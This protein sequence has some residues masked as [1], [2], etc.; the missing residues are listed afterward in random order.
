MGY[1]ACDRRQSLQEI[2][3]LG[4]SLAT[5]IVA[6]RSAKVALK[7]SHFLSP[8][9]LAWL[10]RMRQKAEPSR[11][12]ITRQEPRN[13]DS[14]LLLRESSIKNRLVLW[15]KVTA[16]P[17]RLRE[18]PVLS[19]ITCLKGRRPERVS[20]TPPGLFKN[21][22]NIFRGLAPTAGDLFALRAIQHD[23]AWSP[24]TVKQY[25]A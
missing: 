14:R 1:V 3:L 10:R 4:R 21:L 11:F 22:R 15:P 16:N 2:A 25:V 20:N 6:F 8:N 19:Q 9:A 13:E 7:K 17:C 23:V 18:L 24:S 12:C 5:R